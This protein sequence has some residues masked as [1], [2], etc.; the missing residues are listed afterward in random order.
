V[1]QGSARVDPHSVAHV[2]QGSARVDPHSVA[3]VI[4][5]SCLCSR[6]H[7]VSGQEENRVSFNYTRV[8]GYELSVA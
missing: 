6:S 4:R 5:V 3:H 1:G 7:G 8:H 2:G